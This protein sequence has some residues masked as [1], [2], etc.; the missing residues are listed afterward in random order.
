MRDLLSDV[1]RS[2]RLQSTVY[3]RAQFRAPWGMTFGEKPVAVFHVV[4]EGG[5]W[6]EYKGTKEPIGAGEVLLFPH[7]APH[8]LLDSEGA[9]PQPAG[10]LIAHPRQ[11]AGAEV[12]AVFGGS[13][14]VTTLVCGHY[15][16]ASDHPLFDG[17]P[18]LI[19]VSVPGDTFVGLTKLLVRESAKEEPG[20][21][22]LSDRLA[23]ALLVETIR[24]YAQSA[25]A[26]FAAALADEAIAG[27][28]SAFHANPAG[29][30]TVETLARAGGVSRS[31]FAAR[32]REGVDESPMHYVTRWR[33]NRAMDLLGESQLSLGEIAGRVGYESEFAFS[34]AFK[35]IHGLPPGAAR[36]GQRTSAS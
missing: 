25:D 3:F 15:E 12:D 34:K 18:D 10:E 36:R 22:L 31:V 4:T 7:G 35:R 21:E 14:R 30:W 8:A 20:A 5:C 16:R 33:M 9:Q 26:G 2:V 17:L 1:L 6:L 32:F 13:G 27:A 24:S 11:D 23:E 28:L 19:R 29:A